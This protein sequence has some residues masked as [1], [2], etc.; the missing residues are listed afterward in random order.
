MSH[1]KDF[2]KNILS[3]DTYSLKILANNTLSC[4]LPQF[5]FSTVFHFRGIYYEIKRKE[6]CHLI[7]DAS[8]SFSFIKRNTV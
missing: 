6:R 4:L 1:L 7:E 5:F 3:N 8:C 2:Q